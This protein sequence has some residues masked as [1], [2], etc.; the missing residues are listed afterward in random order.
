MWDGV[1]VNADI[2]RRNKPAEWRR[3]NIQA[4]LI[5]QANIE[6]HLTQVTA[7]IT[8]ARHLWEFLQPVTSI[9]ELHDKKLKLT[10][11]RYDNFDSAS[12][13]LG[14]CKE[15]YDEINFMQKDFIKEFDFVHILIEAISQ[16]K[17]NPYFRL[18]ERMDERHR[19]GMSDV[20]T[21]AHFRAQLL[22]K[23]RWVLNNNKRKQTTTNKQQQT[24]A[25]K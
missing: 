4:L 1:I 20:Y 11:L 5:I 10:A 24:T 22:S 8:S 7:D 15:L 16:A 2:K 6:P 12:K 19:E 25:T 13:F 14:A 3:D 21:F 23:E 18:I 9:H 17:G